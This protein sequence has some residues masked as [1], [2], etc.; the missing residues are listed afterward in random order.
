MSAEDDPSYA[1]WGP[2]IRREMD[3]LDN[4]AVVVGHS[5]GGTVLIHAVSEMP[6]KRSL[7]AIVLLAAPF[8]G[9]GGWPGDEFELPTDLGERLP[10]GVAVQAFLRAR[11][12]DGP[13][14]ACRPI[15]PGDP[16]STRAPAA[17]SIPPAQR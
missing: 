16:A 2:A 13:T 9:A 3:A 11:R 4:G 17:R 5:V 15:R 6:L 1:R 7:G 14:V 10:Q 12:P 8:V